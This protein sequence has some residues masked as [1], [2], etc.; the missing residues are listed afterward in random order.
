M[1]NALQIK[2]NIPSTFN[3]N[4]YTYLSTTGAKSAIYL[5]PIF[6]QLTFLVGGI[7]PAT[8]VPTPNQHLTNNTNLTAPPNLQGIGS[9][10]HLTLPFNKTMQLTQQGFTADIDCRVR[11]PQDLAIYPSRFLPQNLGTTG[12][13][14]L[15][16]V[17]LVIVCPGATQ[18]TTT[19]K[20]SLSLLSNEC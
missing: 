9:R 13:V 4:G 15:T 10:K 12:D 2:R 18:P 6:R 11:D 14:N 17:S 16:L 5:P 20:S 8:F 7:Q 19:S 3:F 1:I